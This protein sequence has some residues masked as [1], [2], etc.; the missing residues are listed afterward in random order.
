MRNE[1]TY[2]ATVATTKVVLRYTMEQVEAMLRDHYPE[3]FKDGDRIWFVADS[4]GGG[5]TVHLKGD[6]QP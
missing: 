6:D 5:I 2:Q 1:E 3:D 4:R